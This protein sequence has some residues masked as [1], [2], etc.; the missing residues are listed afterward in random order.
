MIQMKG[1]FRVLLAVLAVFV[2]LAS[3]NNVFG[4]DAEVRSLAE[5]TACP[6]GCPKAT[7]VEVERSPFAE[8]V[9]YEGPTGA[10]TVRCARAAILVGP[11][12]CAQEAGVFRL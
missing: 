8:T 2:S 1:A 12:S 4:D 5:G 3:A 10:I 7:R 9:R 11:Y 6:R